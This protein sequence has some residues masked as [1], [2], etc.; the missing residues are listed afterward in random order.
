MLRFLLYLTLLFLLMT[1]GIWLSR[2]PYFQ[3]AEINIVAPDGSE[4]LRH[5]DKKRLF[6]TMRP[7]LTGSFFNVNLHEAQRAASKLDWVR[8]VKI[9][10]IPP[11][12]IKVTVDEYEPAARWIRNG[13][14]AGLVSTH[15][16]V[17]QA[18]YAEEL[19]EFDGDVNEQKVMFEQ[20]ENFNNQLKP[21]RLRIIRLQYS[22][23]GA[24]SMMLNNGI[25]VR[26]GKDETSTRM[27][28]FVQA[29]PRYLQARAQYI[30]YVDMRYQDAFATRLR[31]DAPPPEPNIEDMMLD[32]E[33]IT[34][35]SNPS[36]PKQSDKPKKP[37]AKIQEKTKPKKQ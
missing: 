24:W 36:S 28:R 15:G 18:A 32:D 14:Q 22:P 5:A 11:A 34:A 27:A 8:S 16:E 35:P 2:Q 3:I 10:R 26:L 23:R 30:D 37:I 17:F 21:L 20:Y 29:F 19:P 1:G 4:K 6:E 33:L 13:E 25:E 31:S 12:Q 7:Y 9:D